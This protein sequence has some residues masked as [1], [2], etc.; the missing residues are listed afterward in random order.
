M[1]N[2]YYKSVD[3]DLGLLKSQFPFIEAYGHESAVS[4]FDW[5]IPDV[6]PLRYQIGIFLKTNYSSNDLA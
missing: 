2:W 6:D 3:L 4:L 5:L 1:S